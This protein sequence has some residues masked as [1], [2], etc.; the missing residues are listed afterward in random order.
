MAIATID[1][2]SIR[3]DLVKKAANYML[4]Q[5]NQET[6]S[7]VLNLLLQVYISEV[8]E[9]SDAVADLLEYRSIAKARG[10]ALDEI[11]HIVGR[12]RIMYNYD[13]DFWFAADKTGVQPD[14]GNWW[15]QN[16]EQ[17]IAEQMDDDTY[18]KWIWMQILENH[19]KFSS[20]PEL[21]NAIN[22]GI[23]EVVGIQKV[24]PMNAKILVSA[25]I[26]LTNKGLLSYNRNTEQ[27]DND[28]LFAYPATTSIS[29][30]EEV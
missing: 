29:E 2:S 23:G 10:K 9:L 14:N 15:C 11:G 24:T 21:E 4:S 17:A 30:V 8:Q 1:Y 3:L 12:G 6:G 19:N 5:Y 13:V 22:D 18:R 25:Q 16:A 28:Y 27:T 7:K 20:V 26:S